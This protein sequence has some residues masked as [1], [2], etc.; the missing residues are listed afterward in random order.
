[1]LNIAG[2]E[3]DFG[4]VVF[5]VLDECERVLILG[6]ELD[7]ESGPGRGTTIVVWAPLKKKGT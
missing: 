4:S 7:I 3:Y 1:M 2:P 6:G 5:A